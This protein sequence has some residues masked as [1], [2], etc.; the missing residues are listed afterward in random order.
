M[1]LKDNDVDVLM[2]DDKETLLLKENESDEV[3]DAVTEREI[4]ADVESE[5]DAVRVCRVAE[6]LD[7]M[8][9]VVLREEVDEFE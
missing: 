6:M 1:L 7:E 5:M 3:H 8:V 9:C 2:V 4:D